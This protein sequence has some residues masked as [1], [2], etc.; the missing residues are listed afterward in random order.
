MVVGKLLSY[1]EGNFSRSMLNFGGV[2]V[3]LFHVIVIQTYLLLGKGMVDTSQQGH[4]S[5]WDFFRYA[6]TCVGPTY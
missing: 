4:I 5:L 3:L 2:V 6:V 1:W